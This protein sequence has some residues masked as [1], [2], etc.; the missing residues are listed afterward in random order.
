MEQYHS[1][2][3]DFEGNAVHRVFCSTEKDEPCYNKLVLCLS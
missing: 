3:F 1:D 2:H